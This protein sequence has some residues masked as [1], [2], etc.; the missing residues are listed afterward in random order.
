MCENI[1]I[2]QYSVTTLLTSSGLGDLLVIEQ[3]VLGIDAGKQLS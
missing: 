3:H 1:Q 2:A